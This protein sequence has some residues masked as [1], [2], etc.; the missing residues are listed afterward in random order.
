VS[1]ILSRARA[2]AASRTAGGVVAGAL[3]V[4]LAWAITAY[5]PLPQLIAKPLV[6]QDTPGAADAIVVLGAGVDPACAP[7]LHS[8]RRTI[9][10][11]R[12]FKKGKAPLVLFTGG[13]PPGR[14][15]AIA[16]VMAGFA[17]E[18]GVPPESILV[19]R[20]SS[21]TWENAVEASKILGPRGIRKVLLV[22][23]SLHMRR[24]EACMR[25]FGFDVLRDAVPTVD[26]YYDGVDLLKDALHEYVGWWY[27]RLRG[28]I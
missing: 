10:A 28:R 12:L 27:Y 9:H 5:T 15:C 21:T 22:S 26:A 13:T 7:D 23:D 2:V 19:E 16:D 20:A 11:A 4:L 6:L 24:G 8:M 14:S 1:R 17:R 18:L 25:R 3:T